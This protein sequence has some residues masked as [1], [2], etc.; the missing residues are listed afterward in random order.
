MF[1]RNILNR[2]TRK[3]YGVPS[4][5]QGVPRQGVPQLNTVV[6]RVSFSVISPPVNPNIPCN[7]LVNKP[8]IDFEIDQKKLQ[9]CQSELLLLL[10][11]HKETAEKQLQRLKQE[12]KWLKGFSIVLFGS[13]ASVPLGF[14][15]VGLA[16]S[17]FVFLAVGAFALGAW[18]IGL[19]GAKPFADK[20]LGNQKRRIVC[21]T[22][23]IK[24]SSYEAQIKALKQ[25]MTQLSNPLEENVAL[26]KA[27]WD[28]DVDSYTAEIKRSNQLAQAPALAQQQPNT[29]VTDKAQRQ[30]IMQDSSLSIVERE[31]KLN[32]VKIGLGIYPLNEYRVFLKEYLLG[33][34][35]KKSEFYHLRGENAKRIWAILTHPETGCI[36]APPGFDIRETGVINPEKLARFSL[37]EDIKG[38]EYIM[39]DLQSVAA[40]YTARQN[41]LG[42]LIQAVANKFKYSFHGEPAEKKRQFYQ[43]MFSKSMKEE[44]AF[45]IYRFLLNRDQERDV[46]LLNTRPKNI[47]NKVIKLNGVDYD[48]TNMVSRWTLNQYFRDALQ[49]YAQARTPQQAKEA[50][51]GL[52]Y[53]SELLHEVIAALM[54]LGVD[55]KAKVNYSEILNQCIEFEQRMNTL[56]GNKE[57]EKERQELCEAIFSLKFSLIISPCFTY[58]GMKQGDTNRNKPEVQFVFDPEAVK[59]ELYFASYCGAL[60]LEAKEKYLYEQL[61]KAGILEKR[62][63]KA[64]LGKSKSK[65]KNNRQWVQAALA[66]YRF[67]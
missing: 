62:K 40:R 46:A 65:P 7:E 30:K 29:P 12:Q 49:A 63:F 8:P 43:S 64:F 66:F 52:I 6:N 21:Q 51:T 17:S 25:K 9:K 10:E 5:T 16:L 34:V 13:L 42:A 56:N 58:M 2:L 41:D 24:I 19:L 60:S 45:E 3:P 20:L 38:R 23:E 22:L 54:L 4:P 55:Q 27:I 35:V 67:P 28:L 59:K 37:P 48:I 14:I 39:M 11:R 44:R 53:W 47:P 1:I 33:G 36:D 50:H 31:A 61:S 57:K 18:C 32:G 15:A 26:N